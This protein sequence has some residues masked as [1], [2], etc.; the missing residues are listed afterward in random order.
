MK[1]KQGNIEIYKYVKCYA[2]PRKTLISMI[3]LLNVQFTLP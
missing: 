2:L 3:D 1:L